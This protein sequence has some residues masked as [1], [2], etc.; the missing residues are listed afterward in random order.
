MCPIYAVLAAPIARPL[1]VDVLLWFTHWRRSGLLRTA[2]RLSTRVLSVDERTFPLRSRKLV[3]IGHGVDV[4][5]LECIERPEREPLTLLALG[6]TS[7]CEG[8]RDDRAGR[9]AG[10]RRAPPR[11]CGRR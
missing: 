2:E 7:P 8:P 9:R 11:H 5:G 10:R 4:S 6:R 1:G 3:A